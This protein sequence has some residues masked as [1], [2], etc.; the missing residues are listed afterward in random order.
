MKK[1]F[2]T[3]DVLAVVSQTVEVEA[4]DEAAAKALAF[5]KATTLQR[6]WAAVVPLRPNRDDVTFSDVTAID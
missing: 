4:K 1:Y 2:V 5:A 6:D 3:M